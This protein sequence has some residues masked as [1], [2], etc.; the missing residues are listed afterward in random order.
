MPT[1]CIYSF[2]FHVFRSFIHLR[3]NTYLIISWWL[4]TNPISE[5]FFCQKMASVGRVAVV[6]GGNK[7]ETYTNNTA[8][9]GIMS[10]DWEF[11][12]RFQ[13]EDQ[14]FAMLA[15]HIFIPWNAIDFLLFYKSLDWTLFHMADTVHAHVKFKDK[16]IFANWD[17]WFLS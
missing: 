3:L 13:K 11:L 7:G 2:K 17:M 10:R 12:Q 1:F 5:E 15:G 8:F 6:T 4:E 9:K 16:C 14:K